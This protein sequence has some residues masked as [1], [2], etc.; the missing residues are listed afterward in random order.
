MQCAIAR[1]SQSSR[2]MDP[3]KTKSI[4]PNAVAVVSCHFLP[5][6]VTWW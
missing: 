3:C 1:E 2:H 5:F 6:R 4:F